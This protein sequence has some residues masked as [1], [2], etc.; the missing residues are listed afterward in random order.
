MSKEEMGSAKQG[1]T[2]DS[3][4]WEGYGKPWR[5]FEQG[6]DVS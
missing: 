1:P 3:G 5:V 2:D 6:R 4:P